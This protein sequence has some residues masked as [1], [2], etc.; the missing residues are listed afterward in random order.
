M[1][2]DHEASTGICYISIE[3]AICLIQLLDD[4]LRI[5]TNSLLA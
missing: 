2:P 4:L 1:P 3:Q 5:V